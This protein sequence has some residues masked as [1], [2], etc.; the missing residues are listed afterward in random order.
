MVFSV[1]GVAVFSSKEEVSSYSQ[2]QVGK[3]TATQQDI[4]NKLNSR[5]KCLCGDCDLMLYECDCDSEQGATEIKNF[6]K[7]N[8][9][10]GQS[11][12]ELIN[13]LAARYGI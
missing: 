2:V 3:L 4:Y 13:S 5:Y 11:E 8:L 10:Q 9:A 7:Y 6:I 1:V 12:A